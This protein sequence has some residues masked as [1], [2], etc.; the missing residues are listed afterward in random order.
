M[1]EVIKT[2]QEVDIAESDVI[3]IDEAARLSNRSIPAIA[4]MLERGSLPW[5]QLPAFGN[6]E[7]RRIQRFTSKAAVSKLPKDKTR[8]LAARKRTNAPKVGRL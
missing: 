2:T 6:T 8:G 1:L 4:A 7:R 5:Y 3:T